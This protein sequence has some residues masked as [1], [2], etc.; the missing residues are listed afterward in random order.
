MDRVD[1]NETVKVSRSVP[2]LSAVNTGTLSA[3]NDLT[4]PA[5]REQVRTIDFNAHAN[6]SIELSHVLSEV[7]QVSMR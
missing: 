7:I 1:R 5:R 3:D 4:A 6:A 2:G